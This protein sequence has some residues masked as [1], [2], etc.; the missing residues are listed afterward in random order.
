[1]IMKTDDEDRDFAK[2]AGI[3]VILIEEFHARGVADVISE[4]GSDRAQNQAKARG[5]KTCLAALVPH[6]LRA[7][8][9]H[10]SSKAWSFQEKV[11][12]AQNPIHQIP[13]L[14]RQTK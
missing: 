10:H 7:D 1:M 12:L 5:S 6:S 3:H 4:G 14:L 9:T 2:S 11:A 13:D 8:L